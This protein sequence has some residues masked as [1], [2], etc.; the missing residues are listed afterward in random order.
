MNL[1]A[2]GWEHIL[3]NV[4]EDWELVFQKDQK[5]SKKQETGYF[6]FRDSY[7]KRLEISYTKI[8]KKPPKVSSVLADYFKSLKKNN[9]KII[10]KKEASMKVNEHNAEYI[11]W[12]LKKEQV[13]G[14]IF[15]W[16]CP[17]SNR[18]LICT[19]QFS[20]DEK[21][22]MKQQL[23]ELISK[24]K[25]HLN[26]DFIIWSAPNLQISTPVYDMHLQ[27]KVFLIGLTFLEF[28]GAN[29]SLLVYRIG[30]ANQKIKD[31]SNLP[32]WFKDNYKKDLPKI[33]RNFQVGE[34]SKLHYKKRENIWKS[35]YQVESKIPKRGMYFETYLW[36]NY[37]KND[38]YCLIFRSKTLPSTKKRETIE[39]I[40]KLAIMVN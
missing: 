8:A 34:F 10:I 39:N 23:V 4:P 24:L 6:G 33:P 40:T 12:E 14:Y 7:Q 28:K 1:K 29:L 21:P 30:L 18:I 9:R 35:S 31:E 27:K 25:C 11:Y 17:E 26:A 13:L 19:T 2:V 20:I 32:E 3:I 38:I 5:K 37:D 16:I 36:L 15:S 22:E